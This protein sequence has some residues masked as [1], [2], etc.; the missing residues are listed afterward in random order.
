MPAHDADFTLYEDEN[1]G[2]AYEHG[3]YA[4]IAMHWDDARRALT[5]GERKGSFPGMLAER[6]FNVVIAGPGHGVGR[7]ITANP[8][9]VVRYSGSAV[10]VGF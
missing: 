10:T 7:A 6:A 9:R 2:Y 3:V 5:I 4:T 8:D 1:D